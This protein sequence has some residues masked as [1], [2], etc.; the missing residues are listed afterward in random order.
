MSKLI[1]SDASAYELWLLNNG[2]DFKPFGGKRKT[3]TLSTMGMVG[4]QFFKNDNL[5]WINL[6]SPPN[7]PKETMK[8][9]IHPKDS[10]IPVNNFEEFTQNLCK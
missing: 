10:F 4:R 3:E 7:A 1:G 8:L 9:I 2:W 5:I 6:G